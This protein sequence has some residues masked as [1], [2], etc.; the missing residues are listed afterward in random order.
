M[1]NQKTSQ[2]KIEAKYGE[3]WKYKLELT[4]SNC[5]IFEREVKGKIIPEILYCFYDGE[6]KDEMILESEK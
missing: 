1:Q 4:C 2:K 3:G 6:R 5:E